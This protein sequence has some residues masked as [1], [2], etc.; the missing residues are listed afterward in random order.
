MILSCITLTFF[1]TYNLGERVLYKKNIAL[2]ISVI[3]LSIIFIFFKIYSSEGKALSE[4]NIAKE[5]SKVKVDYVGKLKDGSIFDES[6]NHG[7]PLEFVIG[8]RKLLPDFENA[9]IGMKEGEEK[10]ITIEAEKAY[11][12]HKKELVQKIEK[13]RLPENIKPEAGQFLQATQ[14]SGEVVEV[15][16]TEV[17]ETDITIDVNHPLAG[18]DILFD[19]KLVEIVELECKEDCSSCKEADTCNKETDCCSGHEDK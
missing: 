4:K 13:S 15:L 1:K 11:G 8:S 5:F 3:L 2:L 7:G 14:K 17:G 16:I 10:T 19:L 18:K 9:I 6:K 12:Q